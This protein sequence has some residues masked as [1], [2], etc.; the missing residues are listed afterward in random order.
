MK[1]FPL[2][3][4]PSRTIQ[5][6]S[7]AILLTGITFCQQEN[8][9][10]DEKKVSYS[11]ELKAVNKSFSF[12]FKSLTDAIA[13]PVIYTYWFFISEPDGDNCPF[14]PS[15]SSFL[16]EG[17]KSHGIFH[18]GLLFWDRF[19][20]DSNIINRRKNYPLIYKGKL[21]DSPDIYFF[22]G[23]FQGFN[24]YSDYLYYMEQK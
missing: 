3:V 13:I 6:L 8:S 22:E 1:T 15:C 16:I 19:T 10:W 17:V 12:E 2:L 20:R 5:I 11:Q 7:I 21:Y 24:S 4:S 9:I 18:G 23:P 14:Y